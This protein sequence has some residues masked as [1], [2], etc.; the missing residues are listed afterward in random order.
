MYEV[1]SPSCVHD[2]QFIALCLSLYTWWWK[3][4]VYSQRQRA[5][6]WPSCTHD[7]QST[8]YICGYPEMWLY[9]SMTRLYYLITFLGIQKVWLWHSHTH[10]AVW[11]DS[12]THHTYNCDT[13]PLF[14][15]RDWFICA[16]CIQKKQRYEIP[17][18]KMTLRHFW[19]SVIFAC[20]KKNDGAS[21]LH[22]G[23]S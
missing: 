10:H 7:G 15:P 8:S 21:F 22:V 2:G 11:R 13:P 12:V 17:P 16:M 23:A 4:H 5:M 9:T 20:R 3:H 14:V 19:R 18:G 1:L 6:N